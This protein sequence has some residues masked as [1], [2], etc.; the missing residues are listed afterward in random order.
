MYAIDWQLIKLGNW[1]KGA[2]LKITDLQGKVYVE[3]EISGEIPNIDLNKLKKGLYIVTLIREDDKK[4][5]RRILK[6]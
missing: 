2:M 5:Q 6:L 3:F 1:S 4:V